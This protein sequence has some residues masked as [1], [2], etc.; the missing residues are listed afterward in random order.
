MKHIGTFGTLLAP[1]T[2]K[3]ALKK[4]FLQSILGQ[5]TSFLSE[6]TT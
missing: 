2:V 4:R 6:K 1:K 5:K 3:K